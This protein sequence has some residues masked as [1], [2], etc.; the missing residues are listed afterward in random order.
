[1]RP[2]LR[3]L[4]IVLHGA[5]IV[6]SKAQASRATCVA[7]PRNRRSA[8]DRWWCARRIAPLFSCK[9][10]NPSHSLIEAGDPSWA[11]SMLAPLVRLREGTNNLF[12]NG[13]SAAYWC[14]LFFILASAKACSAS[15]ART[16]CSDATC[17]RAF[18]MSGSRVVSASRVSA[19][20]CRP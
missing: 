18:A 2:P 7:E 15:S 12:Q 13:I 14:S 11:Q 8:L 9:A 5:D 16:E 10:A 19:V 1:M 6:V 17:R 20:A 3:R 4:V